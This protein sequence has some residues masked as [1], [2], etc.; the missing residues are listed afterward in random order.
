MAPVLVG[1]TCWSVRGR[2]LRGNRPSE[3]VDRVAAGPTVRV[4]APAGPGPGSA[5]GFVLESECSEFIEHLGSSALC[6]PQ[7]GLP[8][9][10][11]SMDPRLLPSPP[12]PAAAPGASD[13]VTLSEAACAGQ[14]NRFGAASTYSRFRFLSGVTVASAVCLYR[15]SVLSR[16]PGE[17]ARR[18]Q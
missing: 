6:S 10:C 18:A 13:L 9:P 17:A 5:R 7:V 11:D 14:Q 8:A 15:A 16:G 3:T 4:A 2:G 12:T 1:R